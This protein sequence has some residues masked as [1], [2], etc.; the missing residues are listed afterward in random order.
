MR[1]EAARFVGTISIVIEAKDAPIVAGID[2]LSV[3][4]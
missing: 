4:G 2:V 1:E 3:E